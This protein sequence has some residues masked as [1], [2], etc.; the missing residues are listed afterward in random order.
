[1]G[2]YGP[3]VSMKS[4][5][6]MEMKEVEKVLKKYNVSKKDSRTVTD[7]LKEAYFQWCKTNAM[8][9][10]TEDIFRQLAGEDTFKAFCRMVITNF[11][12]YEDEKMKE[13]YAWYD[14]SPFEDGEDEE[15]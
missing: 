12:P 4:M 11:M 10:Y 9:N 2:K 8:A 7:A 14:E 13:T 6:Q 3:G 15:Q 1:M 5:M